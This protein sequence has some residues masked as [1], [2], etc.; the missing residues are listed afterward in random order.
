[1]G[2]GRFARR[3]SERIRSG[4]R[5]SGARRRSRRDQRAHEAGLL[6]GQPAHVLR[7]AGG[8]RA[9]DRRVAGKG[10][11]QP[12]GRTELGASHPGGEPSWTLPDWWKDMVVVPQVPRIPLPDPVDPWHVLYP[13]SIIN[14]GVDPDWLVNAASV[15]KYGD[16]L[17]GPTGQPGLKVLSEVGPADGA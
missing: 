4:C 14:P 2:A 3:L 17:I 15:V 12:A 13:D 10:G 16:T 8:H 6:S 5:Q 11:G 9:H 1:D 7:R